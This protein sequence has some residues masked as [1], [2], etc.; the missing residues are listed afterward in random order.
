MQQTFLLKKCYITFAPFVR[1]NSLL[2]NA[3]NSN[4]SMKL[5]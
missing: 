5:S 4:Y 1:R 2:Q 3:K